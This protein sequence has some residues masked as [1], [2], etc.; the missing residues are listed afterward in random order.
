[1]KL[2]LP[3]AGFC[4]TCQPACLSHHKVKSWWRQRGFFTAFYLRSARLAG[5]QTNDKRVSQHTERQIFY[6]C[7]ASSSI[8]HILYVP[9]V[10]TYSVADKRWRKTTN[11]TG[12]MW[13]LISTLD[14]SRRPFAGKF[15]LERRAR[16]SY[17][18]YSSAHQQAII[19]WKV[20]LLCLNQICR[21]GPFLLTLHIRGNLI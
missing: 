16:E 21:R 4:A 6:D 20:A 1:M 13:N 2:R 11:C 5:Q 15:P 9:R 10:Y 3:G 18:H 14:T 8:F 7:A 19:A 17:F 12:E